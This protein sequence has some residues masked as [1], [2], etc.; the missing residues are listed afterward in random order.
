M[1]DV[2]T[3]KFDEAERRVLAHMLEDHVRALKKGRKEAL[4][5]IDG[6]A[7]TDDQSGSLRVALTAFI[8]DLEL[9]MRRAGDTDVARRSM[10]R[11]KEV[12]RMLEEA[13]VG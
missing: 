2:R 11:C 12:Q 8:R 13:R 9:A 4:I 5:Q 3:M 1:S 6:R 10:A 7:L